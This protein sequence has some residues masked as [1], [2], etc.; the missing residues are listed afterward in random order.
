MGDFYGKDRPLSSQPWILEE[1]VQ[2]P[3]IYNRYITLQQLEE[4][5]VVLISEV[6]YYCEKASFDKGLKYWPS[7]K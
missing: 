5:G 3:N 6:G 2:P 7:L 1:N 4:K